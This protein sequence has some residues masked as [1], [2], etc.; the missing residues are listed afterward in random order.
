MLRLKINKQREE[1]DYLALPGAEP[2][3]ILQVANDNLPYACQCPLCGGTFQIPQGVLYEIEDDNIPDIDS[4]TE[5]VGPTPGP[6]TQP[7]FAR[8]GNTETEMNEGPT[9]TETATPGEEE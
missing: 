8:T 5:P 3:T 7:P 2:L 1:D 9:P 6:A 4:G